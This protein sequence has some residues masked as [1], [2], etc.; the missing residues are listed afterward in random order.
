MKA[1]GAP[2]AAMVVAALALATL[3]AVLW[4]R[5]LTRPSGRICSNETAAFASLRTCLGAQ[6]QFHRTP[7]YGDEVGL[8]H[9]NPWNGSGFPDLYEV[10]GPGSGGKK[11]KL[12]DLALARA[13]LGGTP[14]YGYYF[15]EILG[16]AGQGPYD[17]ST[18][19]GLCAF[20]AEY[21]RSGRLTYII[22]VTGI[23]LQ[24]DTKGIPVWTYPAD[25]K[26]EGWIPV[27]SE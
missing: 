16:T 26:A 22:D 8:A 4:H 19:C 17:F 12:I 14:R 11:L 7:F 15:C 23:V 6:N 20:P 9:A 1:A 10:G 27:G 5:N 25:P 18:D 2:R 24:K 13:R 3:A 21:G